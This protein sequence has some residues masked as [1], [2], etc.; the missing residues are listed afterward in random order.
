MADYY[1]RNGGVN[2]DGTL[3]YGDDRDRSNEAEV[4]SLLEQKWGC[5]LREFGPL[6]PVDRYAI[7]H[8]RLRALIE[9]KCRSHDS[10]KY[11][12]VFLNVRKWITMTAAAAGLKVKPFFVVRFADRT[13]FVNLWNVDASKVRMG[14]CAEVVKS[15]T[16]IEPVIEIPLSQITW[17]T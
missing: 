4:A 3:T 11:P 9:I 14:G 6:C 2:S 15:Q 10:L 16:D 12:T 8:N 1:N 13:G 7:Q 5:T 17:L